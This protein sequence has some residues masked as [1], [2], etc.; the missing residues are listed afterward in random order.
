M[1]TRGQTLDEMLP[2]LIDETLAIFKTCAGTIWLHEAGRDELQHALSRGWFTQVSEIPM[3]VCEGI[4]GQVFRTGETHVSREFVADP[5]VR[6]AMEC[7]DQ[8]VTNS[9]SDPS[10][11][12]G[13]RSPPVGAVCVCLSEQCK[14]PSA[15]FLFRS[16]CRAK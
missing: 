6:A 2:C 12:F 4:G 1:I 8:A 9:P 13:K 16:N 3:N 5:L 7:E 15:S 14:K 11:A 10:G